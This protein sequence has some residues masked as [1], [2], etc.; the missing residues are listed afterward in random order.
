MKETPAEIKKRL[1]EFSVVF[2][3]ALDKGMLEHEKPKEEAP[4]KEKT[5]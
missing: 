4:K 1:D 3:E 5:A 2:G